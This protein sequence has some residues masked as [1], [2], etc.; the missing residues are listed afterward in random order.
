MKFAST[1]SRS[2]E[3]ACMLRIIRRT[4]SAGAVAAV[5]ATAVGLPV[6]APETTDGASPMMA[7]ARADCPPDCGGGPGNGGMPSGPPGGGTEFVPPSIPAM[8]SYDPGRGQPPLDQNN[9]ISIYN[10]SAPQP[11]QAAQ[12]SQAPA[13]NQDGTYNRAANGE[14]QPINHNAP[15]NQQLNNN[16]QRLSDQLNQQQAGQQQHSGRDDLQS[17][18]DND[19]RQRCESVVQPLLAQLPP[20]ETALTRGLSENQASGSDANGGP[21]AAASATGVSPEYLAKAAEIGQKIQEALTANGLALDQCP[22]TNADLDSYQIESDFTAKPNSSSSDVPKKPLCESFLRDLTIED[23]KNELTKQGGFG[24]D[25]PIPNH[26]DN[27]PTKGQR[28]DLAAWAYLPGTANQLPFKISAPIEVAD[29]SSGD[30]SFT[31]LFNTLAGHFDGVGS[32]IK[33]TFIKTAQMVAPALHITSFVK[34][35]P[36]LTPWSGF[37]SVQVT[38]E[39][40]EKIAQANWSPF[41][42]NV[43]RNIA[44]E[45]A[46]PG[47]DCLGGVS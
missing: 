35:P 6:I 8:P 25:F 12:P 29:V 21:V 3:K 33:F 44:T 16:W 37:G 10:S 45:R 17:S 13:Q 5:V 1:K 31:I 11:S 24:R 20:V 18:R 26:P 14:Q 7:I 23:I 2:A 36:Y 41:L 27:F 43:V 28:I 46:V 34:T 42:E 15:N 4:A 32:W 47:S 19:A 38:K 30:G 22:K 40:Y 39:Q 9:G